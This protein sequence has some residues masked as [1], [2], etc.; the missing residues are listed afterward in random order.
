MQRKTNNDFVG[1]KASTA[2][3]RMEGVV[4]RMECVVATYCKNVA[5]TQFLNM[6]SCQ[7][8]RE[9]RAEGA[10][11]KLLLLLLLLC[12]AI[13][14]Y[15]ARSNSSAN[16]SAESIRPIRDASAARKSAKT[17]MP[18]NQ[19]KLQKQIHHFGTHTSG[20]HAL[21]GLMESEMSSFAMQAVAAGADGGRI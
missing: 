7:C 18:A 12:D 19:Q 4:A 6:K 2:F 11:A 15:L 13:Y 20:F 14:P 16:S 9:T 8:R 17:S 10:A 5:R 21:H 3:A 1:G